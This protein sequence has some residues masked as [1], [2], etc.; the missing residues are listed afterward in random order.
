MLAWRVSSL[1]FSHTSFFS[2]L[3]VQAILPPNVYTHFCY[4]AICYSIESTLKSFITIIS[5][6]GNPHRL[7]FLLSTPFVANAFDDVT[8]RCFPTMLYPQCGFALQS[9]TDECLVRLR[10]NP[11]R[12][13][14]YQRRLPSR[15]HSTTSHRGPY[16]QCL[17]AVRFLLQAT[18]VP[19]ITQ[20]VYI[21]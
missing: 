11:N 4:F 9:T 12:H 14:F 6:R 8:S 13:G 21:N 5:T 20:S 15:M 19:R 16:R 17:S 2:F 3:D 1:W 7:G 18:H 10:S